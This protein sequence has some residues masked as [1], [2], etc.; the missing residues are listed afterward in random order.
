MELS[1]PVED[2]T[3]EEVAAELERVRALRAV[4]ETVS[5]GNGE[6]RL[7]EAMGF[8]EPEGEPDP[9]NDDEEPVAAWPHEVLELAGMTLHVRKPGESALIAVAMTGTPGLSPQTQM[10]I[11]TKFLMN[12]LSPESFT[13]VIEAMMTPDSG[14]QMQ[15]VIEAMTKL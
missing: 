8:T 1:K 7:A 11:L 4:P 9:E 13:E 15:T 2:M 3:R 6:A 5:N 12:H 10:R 14:V